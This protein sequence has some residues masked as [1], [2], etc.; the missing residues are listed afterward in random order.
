[1]IKNSFISRRSTIVVPGGKMVLSMELI[2]MPIL[3]E[4]F[5]AANDNNL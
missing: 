3:E 4:I 2:L 1:M 5:A